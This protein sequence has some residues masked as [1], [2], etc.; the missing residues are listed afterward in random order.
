MPTKDKLRIYKSKYAKIPFREKN[1]PIPYDRLFQLEKMIDSKSVTLDIG[2]GTG[3]KTLPLA[4]LCKKFYG[5]DPS[6]ELLKIAKRNSKK[7][8]LRNVT[9][10]KGC[11]EELPFSNNS[12]NLTTVLLARFIPEEIYRVLKPGGTVYIELPGELDKRGIKLLFG[13]DKQG[14]RG[15]LCELKGGGRLKI[16]EKQ[17]LSTGFVQIRSLS[18]FYDCYYP[19]LEDLIM[20]LEEVK[21]TVRNFSRKK[22]AKVLN[23][24]EKKL[25]KEKGIKVRKHEIVIIGTKPK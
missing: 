24:I 16:L 20:L 8:L 1:D 14:L 15:Y 18:L 11:A 9:L 4:K 13:S 3:Y 12:V 25:S 5:I 22:D 2:I 6:P 17:L 7:K 10:I 23:L 21:V 19:T